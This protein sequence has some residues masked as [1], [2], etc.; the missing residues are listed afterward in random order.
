MFE[1]LPKELCQIISY[2]LDYPSLKTISSVYPAFEELIK[3]PYYF[4]ARSM[5]RH[6]ITYPMY[7]KNFICRNFKHYT[8]NPTES[9]AMIL[10]D[11]DGSS[12]RYEN[13]TLSTLCQ[14]LNVPMH[15]AE[16]EYSEVMNYLISERKLL[17]I[18]SSIFLKVHHDLIKDNSLNIYLAI[19]NLLPSDPDHRKIM[20]LITLFGAIKYRSNKIF[21]YLIGLLDS[22]SII[23]SQY[24]LILKQRPGAVLSERILRDRSVEQYYGTTNISGGRKSLDYFYTTLLDLCQKYKNKTIP[25][26]I[27]C[28]ELSHDNYE[29]VSKILTKY[30]D[31]DIKAKQLLPRA[32]SVEA[33]RS[34]ILC[35]KYD[36]G[37]IRNECF[38]HYLDLI[39]PFYEN[40]SVRSIERLIPAACFWSY[41]SEMGFT[42]YYQGLLSTSF[43]KLYS[44]KSSLF[45]EY[46]N[47][48]DHNQSPPV[49]WY[50]RFH[51]AYSNIM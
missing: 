15:T 1:L 22:E 5:R 9:H 49:D 24:D 16:S 6:N 45:K 13:Q 20:Y 14:I 26:V 11:T 29:L 10:C 47:Y 19:M 38:Y 27:C 8:Q 23:F 36:N 40:D 18:Q 25:R 32:I 21:K 44:E 31:F 30:P 12:I 48:F 2:S 39:K 51:Q 4:I 43:D 33:V 42:E 17:N 41:S 46:I 34:V 7:R 37:K 35:Y 50:L 28:E 3:S